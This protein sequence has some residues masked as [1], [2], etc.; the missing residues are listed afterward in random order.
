MWDMVAFY[1]NNL[2]LIFF[3]YG[4]VYVLTGF[5]IL[6]KNVESSQF[7]LA[8]F[9]RLFAVFALLHGLAD[10][11]P[12]FLPL[13]KPNISPAA[14]DN[15]R[16]IAYMILTVS[17]VY[18][19]VFGLKV[20]L[21]KNSWVTLLPVGILTLWFGFI[22]AIRT[23]TDFDAWLSASNALSRY[24]L[25][26]PAGLV[27]AYAFFKQS[28]DFERLNIPILIQ[29]M[30]W[31]A[32]FLAVYGIFTGLVVPKA[33]FFPANIV[34]Y[35]TFI[36]ATRVP[37]QI[38]RFVAGIGIGVNIIRSLELFDVE[39][40]KRMEEAERREA[41]SAERGRISR[42]IHDGTI[43]SLYGIGLTLERSRRL[44]A[45]TPDHPAT[46]LL[47][48]AV[49]KLNDTIK[50]VRS[51][52][53]DLQQIY[54]QDIKLRHSLLEL[55]NEFAITTDVYPVFNYNE[56]GTTAL[57]PYQRANIYHVV[58]E[59]LNNVRRHAKANKVLVNVSLLKDTI[60][61][62]IKDDG[63][64]F[65][66]AEAV[67]QQD[68]HRGIA[69]MM[70]RVKALGGKIDLRSAPGKGTEIRMSILY[71]GEGDGQD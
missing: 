69:N 11:A 12:A 24:F 29:H 28:K 41:I 55:I 63:C 50:D 65:D 53:M 45:G 51:Y 35:D 32:V 18:L 20:V 59:A 1:H 21:K 49:T 57:T 8:K 70:E 13:H 15:L 38:V 14:Y 16:L 46:E 52:I 17:Y 60:E 31:G 37:V 61:I 44:L 68:R 66:V 23:S 67:R 30:R 71:G 26:F 43:Q 6:V 36:A 40:R 54:F 25:G 9:I 62:A 42:E 2:Q 34:N 22:F 64:G 33:N 39:R 4:L 56:N 48:Y 3:V 5:A 10:W 19:F 27:A 58:K 47:E 7:K